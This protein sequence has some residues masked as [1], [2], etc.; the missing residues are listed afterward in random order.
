MQLETS[1][2]AGVQDDAD[3][4]AALAIQVW[5]DTYA[6]EGIRQSIAQFVLSE[7]TPTKFRQRLT[8]SN[9]EVVVAEVNGHLVGF[10][11]I[12]YGS[13]CP[14]RPEVS[15]EIE[16]LYVQPRFGRA[17]IGSKLLNHCEFLV[18]RRTPTYPDVWFS[19]NAHN[20]S[21]LAFYRKRG[22]GQV[23]SMDF[24]LSGERHMN[25]VFVAEHA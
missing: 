14:L 25:F 21:A 17:G 20:E 18:R 5:L 1:L 22:Y 13:I 4:L 3:C 8:D 24:E 7:F 12:R 19:V 15:S 6:T 2:R 11:I 10:S 9:I 16:V 23:G